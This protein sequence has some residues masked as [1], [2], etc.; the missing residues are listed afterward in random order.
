LFFTLSTKTLNGSSACLP[1]SAA[2]SPISWS[3]LSLASCSKMFGTSPEFYKL[4]ISSRMSSSTIWLSVNK[5]VIGLPFG[6]AS[7]PP[8][9][10]KILSLSHSLNSLKEKF[11]LLSVV[12]YE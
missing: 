1:I 4:L 10:F 3:N 12:S 8:H 6:P 2:N 5:K 11:F 7:L 9:G